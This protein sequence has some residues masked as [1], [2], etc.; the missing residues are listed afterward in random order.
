MSTKIEVV[1]GELSF[2]VNKGKNLRLKNNDAVEYSV[3]I[4]PDGF[5][6][7]SGPFDLKKNLK[8]KADG[9]VK[10]GEFKINI[11]Q[12]NTPEPKS[13]SKKPKTTKKT[14][15]PPRMIIKVE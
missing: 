14:L 13:K 3:E 1:N 9:S 2:V 15:N 7:E 6:K 8:I 11:S 12:K 10:S 4:T 5:S